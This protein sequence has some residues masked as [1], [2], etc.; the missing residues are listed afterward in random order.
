MNL[1]NLLP[2]NLNLK[3]KIS[4]FLKDKLPLA[5]TPYDVVTQVSGMKLLRFKKSVSATVNPLRTPLFI[6]PSMINRYYVL[7]LLPGKSFIEY[8]TSQGVDVFLLDWGAPY[9]EDNWLSLDQLIEHRLEYF[10]D[11]VCETAQSEK[12]NIFGH[13]LGGTLATLYTL[14]FQ[15]KINSLALLTAPIDFDHGGKLGVWVKQ[16]QFNPESV[17]KAYGNMPWW[18]LQTSFQMLKPMLPVYKMEKFFKE[19]NNPEFMK[20]FWALEVWSQDNVSFPG[21]CFITLIDELYRKNA[22]V[23]G[24]FHL[25]GKP[26]LLQ[27]LNSPVLNIAA[28]DDHIVLFNSTLQNYHVSKE[29]DFESISSAGGHIGSIL[30][31]K[32]QKNVWPQ[33]A[34]WLTRNDVRKH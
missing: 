18:V 22:L 19:F 6:I 16:N 26:L 33:I 30:G 4:P 12:I 29:L 2:D 28:T 32:A 20:N 14:R 27:Q 34:S 21:K 13:C 5:P 23:K 17:T 7:D 8:L 15:E 1:L 11:T 25:S 31:S 24:E 9:D 10:V 3:E